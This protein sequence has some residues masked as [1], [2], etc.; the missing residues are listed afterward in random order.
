MTTTDQLAAIEA[1][2]GGDRCAAHTDCYTSD[3]AALLAMVREQQARLDA[4]TAILDEWATYKPF[5]DAEDTQR[6]YSLGKRHAADAIRGA[7]TATEGA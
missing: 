3:I 2:R 6:W 5:P 7:L 4:A 1:R